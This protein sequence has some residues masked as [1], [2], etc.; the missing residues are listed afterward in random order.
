M[1]VVRRRAYQLLIIIKWQTDRHRVYS[2]IIL[3]LFD[4]RFE[5]ISM[6]IHSLSRRFGLRKVSERLITHNT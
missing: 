5:Y 4:L 2:A 1:L 3:L 6:P